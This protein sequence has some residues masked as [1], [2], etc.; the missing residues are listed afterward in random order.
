MNFEPFIADLADGHWRHWATER[1][2]IRYSGGKRKIGIKEKGLSQE[3][4][5]SAIWLWID[6]RTHYSSCAWS[7]IT[8]P[9]DLLH[10]CDNLCHFNASKILFPLRQIY[11]LTWIDIRCSVSD[12]SE[13]VSYSHSW[14]FSIFLVVSSELLTWIRFMCLLIMCL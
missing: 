5:G 1:I 12:S 4:G 10:W 2:R 3:C 6:H 7:L 9:N 13:A 8:F 14:H 11:F